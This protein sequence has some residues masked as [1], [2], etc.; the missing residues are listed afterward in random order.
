M[1]QGRFAHT[2]DAKGRM[3]I[4]APIRGQ[5][6]EQY[7]TE[8]L[9]ITI[10][11]ERERILHLHPRREWETLMERIGGASHFKS[12]LNDFRRIYVSGATPGA[13]DKQGRITLS[14]E[15]RRWAGVDKDVV[16]VGS[17]LKRMELWS[18]ATWERWHETTE[19]EVF[20]GIGDVLEQLGL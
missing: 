2:V 7:G 15:Q 5:L 17:G 1:F 19:D 14:A 6:A 16:L 12:N 3:A 9:F 8:D 11:K 10:Y 13:P 18:K 4:P 20:E